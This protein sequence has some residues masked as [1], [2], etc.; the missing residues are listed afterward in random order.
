MGISWDFT[1]LSWG[2][3]S[4]FFL[5]YSHALFL[6]KKLVRYKLLKVFGMEIV[7]S[8]GGSH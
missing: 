4:K 6:N 8:V 1:S 7:Q 5:L 2:F 3:K